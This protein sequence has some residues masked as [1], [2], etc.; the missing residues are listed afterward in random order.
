MDS[1]SLTRTSTGE[2]LNTIIQRVTLLLTL[3]MGLT[4]TSVSHSCLQKIESA[5]VLRPTCASI[6]T[7]DGPLTVRRP[8]PHKLD[9]DSDGSRCCRLPE[10]SS[11]PPA[12]ARH[13]LPIAERPPETP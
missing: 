13:T 1:S 6:T 10:H 4:Y 7:I 3:W 2:P 8:D 12:S 11:L 9:G 5:L